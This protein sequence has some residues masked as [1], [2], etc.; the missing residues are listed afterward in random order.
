MTRGAAIV[1]MLMSAGGVLAQNAPILPNSARD[2]AVCH[3][4]WVDAFGNAKAVLLIERPDQPVVADERT[5]YGCHDGSVGDSRVRVWLG[6]GHEMGAKPPADMTVPSELP[7][8]DGTIQC[9]TCH[10]AHGAGDTAVTLANITFLRTPNDR[11]QMCIMCHG[12]QADDSGD[13]H[14]LVAMDRAI[15]PGEA[16]RYAEHGP[17]HNEVVCQSCHTPHGG[18]ET[19]LLVASPNAD[20]LCLNCHA[21]LDE[22]FAETHPI[23]GHPLDVRLTSAEQ[24]QAIKT[25]DAHVGEDEKVVCLSCHQMHDA[26]QADYLLQETIENAALCLRCHSGYERVAGGAHDLRESA[27]QETNARGVTAAQA[28]VCSACHGAHQAARDIVTAHGDPNGRCVTCHQAGA[29]GADAGALAFVHPMETENG[30]RLDTML[31]LTETA[32]DAQTITCITCHNPHKNTLD[33]FLRAAPDELCASCHEAQAPMLRTAGHNFGNRPDVANELAAKAQ[34]DGTCGACHGVHAGTGP[35]LWTATANAPVNA[36]EQCTICHRAGHFSAA[37][38]PP[39]LQHPATSPTAAMDTSL[40]V[41]AP[42]GSRAPGGQVACATC[43]DPHVNP[44]RARNMLR[45]AEPGADI[46]TLCS[47]CHSQGVTLPASLHRTEVLAANLDMS[48]AGVCGPCHVVHSDTVEGTW[49]APLGTT[50]DPSAAHCMGCHSPEGGAT[51]VE[52]VPHPRVSLHAVGA[53]GETGF[54]PLVDP[55]GQPGR[56]G[57]ISCITCHLPHGREFA[58]EPTEFLSVL[59]TAHL[60]TLRAML[61]PYVAP[62]LC[63][64]CHGFDGLHRY[65]YYHRLQRGTAPSPTGEGLPPQ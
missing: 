24:H 8:T 16:L 27:P 31:P 59:N 5:C 44:Q 34:R 28:G 9:R 61:R 10:T 1:A 65:L 63:S 43:H 38:V 40:P 11:G 4:E 21:W 57:D 19:G 47:R 25:W 3:L 7:L 35:I 37:R 32:V 29:C 22:R 60:R 14:A 42:D 6:H 39:A 56:D 64:S 12:E 62:N 53:P 33:R 26:P 20:A 50:G 51:V 30:R 2:C 23:G 41:F 17:E 13:H 54:L 45:V 36:T 18:T 46:E 15:P 49:A 58:Q 52:F 55:E 48:Q